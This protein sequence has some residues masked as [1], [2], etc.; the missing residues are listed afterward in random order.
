MWTSKVGAGSGLKGRVGVASSW[1]RGGR[2]GAGGEGGGAGAARGP[3]AEFG[4]ERR[5]TQ[6]RGC[7]ARALLSSDRNGGGGVEG[8]SGSGLPTNPTWQEVA[9][10]ASEGADDFSL[11]RRKGRLK[12]QDHLIDF[13]IDMHKTH[14]TLEVMEKVQTWIKGHKRDKKN[15]KL[16]KLVPQIGAFRTELDLVRALMEYD[17]HSSLM[18]RQFVPPNFAEIRHILNLSQIHASAPSLKLATFDADGTLYD[19]GKHFTR[20]SSMISLILGLLSNEVNVAIITAAGYPGQVGRY[21]E[22]LEGLLEVFKELEVPKEVL[23]RFYI[24]GGECN[25]LLKIDE[26]YKLYFIPRSEWASCA[27]MWDESEIEALLDRAQAVLLNTASK[28]NVEVNLVRK[29]RAVG[30]SPVNPSVYEVLEELALTAQYELQGVSS[31]PFCA[32]NGG[33]DCFVDVGNKGLGLEALLS[34]IGCSTE[35]VLHFGDRF[36]DTGNDAITKRR[37]S[38]IWVANPRETTWFIKRILKDL[39]DKTTIF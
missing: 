30:V 34:Y 12:E 10:L 29:E 1:A 8:D 6:L 35:T 19:D 24:M 23:D 32:F 33:A 2:G 26:N 38:T 15:S 39:D 4:A 7:D 16:K 25:Y 13:M 36:T 9:R 31:V 21:E 28:L 17:G 20:D 37:F 5:R 14:T 22:R 3:R 11:L 18:E 27:M